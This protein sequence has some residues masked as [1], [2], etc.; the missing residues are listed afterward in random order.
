MAVISRRNRRTGRRWLA[1]GLALTFVLGLVLS[2]CGFNAQTNLPYT[3]ADGVNLDVGSVHVRNLM[4]LS[5][6]DGEGFL[7]ASMS[8]PDQDALVG[9]SGTVI[10]PDGSNGGEL[11]FTFPKPVALANGTAVVLTDSPAFVTVKGEGLTPGNTV[12]LT[13]EFSSA[14]QST[15]QVPVVDANHPAY[16]TVSPSPSASSSS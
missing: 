10:K 15:L 1:P 13:L 16:V 6:T 8:S 5:R 2:A 3:P 11:T 14:G 4:I 9:A 7:S 12:D